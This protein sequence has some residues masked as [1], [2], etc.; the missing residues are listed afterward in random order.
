MRRETNWWGVEIGNQY[1]GDGHLNFQ[2]LPVPLISAE[3]VITLQ[4]TCIQSA[5]GH[6]IFT[7]INIYWKNAWLHE[8]ICHKHNLQVKKKKNDTSLKTVHCVTKREIVKRDLKEQKYNVY[9]LPVPCDSSQTVQYSRMKHTDVQKST[10]Y[11]WQE[12][13]H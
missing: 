8:T 10:K 1:L 9:H 6:E 11:K 5:L 2:T 7:Y 12:Q 4:S 13:K 3:H